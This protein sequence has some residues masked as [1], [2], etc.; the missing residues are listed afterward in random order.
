M[1]TFLHFFGIGIPYSFAGCERAEWVWG[2]TLMAI[3][4]VACVGAVV[5]L[6]RLLWPRR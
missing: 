6:S 2:L 3:L 4:F 5:I 1:K